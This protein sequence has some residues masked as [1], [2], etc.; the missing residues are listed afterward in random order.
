M[1]NQSIPSHL[2]IFLLS[3]CFLLLLFGVAEIFL[4]IYYASNPEIILYSK[5]YESGKGIAHI[6]DY[7]FHLNSR[8]YKDTEFMKSLGDKKYD[9]IIKLKYN[10]DSDLHLYKNLKYLNIVDSRITTIPKE[11]INLNE[12]RSKEMN[13]TIKTIELKNDAKG[14]AE[15]PRMRKN[16][17]TKLQEENPKPLQAWFLIFQTINTLTKIK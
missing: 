14:G 9:L 16:T 17:I 15:V 13:D 4:R 11:L 1:N 7:D 5:S 8:G 3:F 2:R 12:L 6:A 10:D